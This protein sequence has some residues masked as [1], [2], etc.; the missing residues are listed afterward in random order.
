[1][2]RPRGFF[3]DQVTRLA[4]VR[5]FIGSIL[6]EAVAQRQQSFTNFSKVSEIDQRRTCERLHDA[7]SPTR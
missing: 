3:V 2:S 5:A 1:V 4:A 6:V 7:P